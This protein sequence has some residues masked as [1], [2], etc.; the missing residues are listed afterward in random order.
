MEKQH[1]DL[2]S[3]EISCLWSSYL[4]DSM[5]IC[6]FKY[7][8]QGIKDEQIKKVIKHALDLSQQ[9][10]EIIKNIFE[11]EEIAVPKGF[12][13]HD[14]NLKAKPLFTDTFCLFYLKN[15]T[16][17]G[18]VANAT[19]LPNMYREDILAFYSKCLTS[20]NELHTEA[21]HL[22]LEKGLAVRPPQI[23]KPQQVEFIR[24]QSF[25][26]EALGESRPLTGQEVTNLYANIQTNI[27]GTA[28]AT[29]FAQVTTTKKIR[30]YM[31]KGKEISKKHFEVF[32]SYLKSHDLPVP[33]SHD[34]EITTSTEAPFSEKLMMFHFSLMI[35]AGVGNYGVSISQSQRSDLVV[36]Y[37][38]LLT[39]TLAYSED[40]ANIMINKEW[41]EKP[42]MA[43]DRKKLTKDK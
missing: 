10:V 43:A 34:H 32:S 15:M 20:S 12:T 26:F 23:P 25:L 24:K 22:L 17:G 27:M 39:E 4:A 18:L 1:I 7:L 37:S 11:K 30:E 42:P 40:G 2:T 21:T 16:K 33:V 38:R 13:E 28:I 6:V 31:L 29:A 19:V 5:S 35:Y 3:A 14:V 9:H 8:V 36:D 41:L